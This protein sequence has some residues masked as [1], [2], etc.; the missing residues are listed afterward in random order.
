MANQ[1]L[2]IATFYN[3]EMICLGGG[4]S[5]EDWF[6]DLISERFKLAS[7]NFLD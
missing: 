4:I 1:L 2:S 5:E 3:P 7:K 6:I